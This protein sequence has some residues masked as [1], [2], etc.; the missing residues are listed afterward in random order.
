MDQSRGVALKLAIAALAW[1]VG[2]PAQAQLPLADLP[3]G[4]LPQAQPTQQPGACYRAVP[5]GSLADDQTLG[6]ERAAALA[7][8]TAG[9]PFAAMDRLERVIGDVNS[10]SL[11]G[12][13]AAAVATLARA[14]D[15]SG[16]REAFRGVAARLS[17]TADLSQ[18]DR[19]WLDARSQLNSGRAAEAAASAP[20]DSTTSPLARWSA[21]ASQ[22][23]AALAAGQTARAIALVSASLDSARALSAAVDG[24]VSGPGVAAFARNVVARRAW[25]VLWA[26]AVAAGAAAGEVVAAANAG[27]L[28]AASDTRIARPADVHDALRALGVPGTDAA[29]TSLVWADGGSLDEVRTMGDSV[30][31]ADARSARAAYRAA[32]LRS[33]RAERLAAGARLT[34]AVRATADSLAREE[35]TL[36]VLRDS[37]AR[38]DSAVERGLRTFRTQIATKAAAVQNAVAEHLRVLDTVQAQALR[39][40]ATRR[41]H[42]GDR[43]AASDYR[44]VA[45]VTLR[46]LDGALASLDIARQRDSARARVARVSASLAAAR[47]AQDSA[48]TIAIAAERRIA[49]DADAE[50]A[51]A[52]AEVR[53]AD[54]SRS[55]LIQ[56][57]T[58]TVTQVLGARAPA[59]KALAGQVA[60]TVGFARAHALFFAS[61]EG[62]TLRAPSAEV[63]RRRDAALAAATE[64]V[65]ANQG[66]ALRPAVLYELGEL[67]TRKADADFAT[68]QRAGSNV[69]RPDYGPAI[70][71]FDSLL[72]RYPTD[73]RVDAAAYTMGTLAFASARYDDAA[74]AFGVVMANERS[75]FRA[76][77]YFRD[78]DAKFEQAVK[79]GS[80]TRRAAL[81]S[82]AASYA[83]VIE[84]AP[85]G[86]L[87]FM[88]LYKLGWSNYMQAE[89]QNSDEYRA[90]VEQFS[91]LVREVDALPA[92]RQARLSLRQEAI[93]YLA[94]AITQLGGA[95]EAVRYLGAIPDVTTRMLVLRRVAH[96]LRDQGEFASA[97]I[98]YRGAVEQ[99]P[100]HPAVLD[101]RVEL[102]DLF[103]SRLLEPARAQ[104][105]RLELIEHLAPTSPWGTANAD[106][107]VRRRTAVARERALREAGSYAMTQRGYA[108]AARLFAQYMGEFAA[109]DSAQRISALEGDARFGARDW[110]GSGLAH[111]RTSTRWARDSVLEAAAR[112]NAVVAFDSALVTA[113]RDGAARPAPLKEIEDSLFAATERFVVRAP[114]A[115]AKQALITM[116][117][118]ASEAQRWDVVVS[119]FARVADEWPTDAIA[120]DA[121]KFVADARY[122]LGQY[123]AAQAEWTR[124]REQAL[125]ATPPRRALAD[126][127]VTVRVAA[128]AAVADSLVRRGMFVAAADSILAPVAADI[129]DATRAADVLRN[130]IEVHL[131]ADSVARGRADTV[132][133]RIARTR[134]I[135]AIETLASRYPV[136]THTLTYSALRARLLVDVGQPVDAAM[137]LETLATTNATW[138]GRADAMVRA[139]V[140]LDSIGQPREAAAAFERFAAAYPRDARAADAQ[141]N[142]AVILRDAKLPADAARAF[143][144][145]ASRFPADTR[146][147]DALAARVLA[148]RASGDTTAIATDLIRLCVRP[149]A[150]LAALGAAAGTICADRTGAREFAAGMTQWDRYAAL[151]LEIRTRAQLTRA[152]VDAASATKLAV[153]RSITGSFSRAV[154]TGSANWVAAGTFQ[155]GLAQWYYG[156]FLRDVV[157]PADLSDAQRDG[158]RNG[159]A[160]Q[161]QQYFDAAIAAWTALVQKAEAEQL[162]GAWVDKTR[163]ALKGEGIPPRTLAPG[164]T[165]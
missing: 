45:E 116:G 148:I 63:A 13:R 64:V 122:R 133:S 12:A 43:A 124:A 118:R 100:M 69:E 103:Q 57:A 150:S 165:P 56:R 149:A 109:A 22:A 95:E 97:V 54:E 128:A 44:A 160:Q 42:D 61:V 31:E 83:R 101:T 1:A 84:L 137:A 47:A 90:A 41:I 60:V 113:R 86:D 120:P 62:D 28:P 80:T 117:R 55:A 106:S 32:A 138:A 110:Y 68:A 92:E 152:G 161:A 144:A 33:G 104:A 52:D 71:R 135:R 164:G 136:Y 26:P 88:A 49:A 85:G 58:T 75:A 158:A 147:G 111:A 4:Q 163:A 159:S 25:G 36:R 121:R 151:K 76:E 115:D 119:A 108:D 79:V 89:R 21:R 39:V 48:L 37:V 14:Y 123:A 27:E 145:F 130:V 67:L 94:I 50:I 87:Y 162:S 35:A 17:G 156:L 98:V 143:Q 23:N 132:G 139:A 9:R 19:T 59:L 20:V 72:T 38:Q 3:Q 65:D 142:A 105:A 51:A 126:S 24:V 46:T 127:I 40:E 73:P 146:V 154:Q 16:C 91:R 34:A 155:S 78:G 74:R 2:Q 81:V 5:A 53:A 114:R 7:D 107:G 10:G 131:V 70:A 66:H 157:L 30:R 6:L 140:L 18:A 93:D 102:V 82:A 129:G 112:R 153:L 29:I 77:G 141:Y 11:R 15:R 134:A 99:V 125:R 96:A 8:L